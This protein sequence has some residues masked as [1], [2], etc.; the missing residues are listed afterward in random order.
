MAVIE[1]TPG[2]E[3]TFLAAYRAVRHEVGDSPGC[4][5]VRVVRG[6]ESPSR[7]LL[8]VEWDSIDAHELFRASDRFGRWRGGVGPHFAAPPQVEHYRAT[9]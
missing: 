3:D 5:S 1:V 6:V 7:F 9:D 2:A 4:R 8:F